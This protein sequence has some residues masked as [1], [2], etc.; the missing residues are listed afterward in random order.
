MRTIFLTFIFLLSG[1][2]S[3][4]LHDEKLSTVQIV[5]LMGMISY[6]I[7]LWIIYRRCVRNINENAEKTEKTHKKLCIYNEQFHAV[8]NLTNSISSIDEMKEL[9]DILET[10]KISFS[11][12]VCQLWISD[13]EYT[14][15]LTCIESKGMLLKN[16][17]P[18][19]FIGNVMKRKETVLIE[20]NSNSCDDALLEKLGLYSLVVCP[21]LSK[22]RRM[23]IILAG[24]SGNSIDQ[25]QIS[26]LES[27][28][29]AATGVVEK[30]EFEKIKEKDSSL[31]ESFSGVASNT[32]IRIQLYE[33][34]QAELEEKTRE[35]KRVLNSLARAR[36]MILQNVRMSNF[37]RNY[38]VL[39]KEIHKSF[40]SLSLQLSKLSEL[41]H[42]LFL[43]QHKFISSRMIKGGRTVYDD[44]V[45]E[46]EYAFEKIVFELNKCTKL[47]SEN[48][49]HLTAPDI[50]NTLNEEDLS[51]LAFRALEMFPFKNREKVEITVDF[52]DNLTWQVDQ[53]HV[54]K[55]FYNLFLN[56]FEAMNFCGK[57][58]IKGKR[59]NGK[60]KIIIRDNGSGI[61]AEHIESVCLPF[62]TT[63][64]EKAG[65]G[66]TI[67]SEILEK[68]GG[69]IEIASQKGMFTEIV[70]I[71]SGEKMTK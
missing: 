55:V 13:N 33:E 54:E 32:L 69:L 22:N 2:I 12:D 27:I 1:C 34:L 71:F 52:E 53:Q 57:L 67:S 70:M 5:I 44:F 62:F 63:K 3:I 28:S 9:G 24:N 66:L 56:A 23:G 25:E 43:I 8:Q 41:H 11:F 48:D 68:Y 37:G 26:L 36:E 47:T 31:L 49:L 59:E 42:K 65:L 38:N 40:S 61:D 58:Q 29:Y 17:M 4:P 16:R 19:D 21:L 6:G 60:I 10:M 30:N 39:I 64:K 45:E 20:K 50:Q 14:E 18:R 35:L 15:K 7:Y 46:F 51:K